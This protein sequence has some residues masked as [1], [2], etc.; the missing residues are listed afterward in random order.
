MVE[1]KRIDKDLQNFISGGLLKLNRWRRANQL[2]KKV[3]AY[4]QT[5]R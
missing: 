2:Q 3:S 4:S 5:L 1:G